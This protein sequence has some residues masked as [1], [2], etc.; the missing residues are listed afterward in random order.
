MSELID[1]RSK[2]PY[3]KE[4]LEKLKEVIKELHEGKTVQEVKAKF[5]DV[6]EGTSPLDISR[7]EVELVKDGLPIEEIQNLCDVHAEV[8]KGSIEE[9]HH[10]DEVP[11]HPVYTL[12]QE[13]MALTNIMEEVIPEDL[14]RFMEDDSDDNRFKL[15]EDINLLWDIDKHY[16]RK[17]NLIFPYLEKAGITAPPQVMWGVDDEIREKIKAAK[18]ELIDYSGDKELVKEKILAATEQA[19]DM[20]FKEESILFP[21]TLDTLTEDEWIKVYE[22]S[23]EI[24]YAVIPP[25][26]EWELKRVNVVKKEEDKGITESGFVKF[27]TGILS[28]KELELMLN[29]IP[30]DFT[31]VDK[32]NIVKYFSQGKERIFARTKAII[33]RTVENCHPPKSAHIVEDLVNDFKSGRKDSESFWIQMGDKFVLIQY[34]AVRD[35]NGEFMGTLEHTMDIAPLRALEGEKRLMS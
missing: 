9:I 22:G 23:E 16:S 19:V 10:P 32:D 12:R 3:D 26:K 11:G 29:N 4:K 2:K 33:G 1:N 35:E 17:E 30:G 27:E 18:K 24:G 31:F 28:S 6:L 5:A 20:I 34:F 15:V 21:M 13:N 7:M 8:F 14:E 25:Q